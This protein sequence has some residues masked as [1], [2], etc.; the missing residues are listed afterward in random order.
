MIRSGPRSR[1]RQP[2]PRRPAPAPL[3]SQPLPVAAPL[4]AQPLPVAPRFSEESE[5]PATL[6]RVP[7]APPRPAQGPRSVGSFVERLRGNDATFEVLVN[8]ARILTLKQDI[9]AGP[10]PAADRRRRPDRSSN[11]PCSTPRQLRITGLRNR[12]DRPVD[13]DR[14]E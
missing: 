11:S 1:R 12:R 3:A 6:P 13:H 9:T 2:R 4:E 5:I 10:D 8:Q 14:A 7:L